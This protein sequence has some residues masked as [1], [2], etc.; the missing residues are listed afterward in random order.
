MLQRRKSLIIPHLDKFREAG[1]VARARNAAT[2][3]VVIQSGCHGGGG[4]KKHILTFRDNAMLNPTQPISNWNWMSNLRRRQQRSGKPRS[5]MR[6]KAR[7][8]EDINLH[9]Y[10]FG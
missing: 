6:E 4:V 8:V 9:T 3:L 1:G 7:G 5:A 2:R 10:L